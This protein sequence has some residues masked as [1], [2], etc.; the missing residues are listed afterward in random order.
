MHMEREISSQDIV[1]QQAFFLGLCYGVCEP[2]HRERILRTHINITVLCIDCIGGNGHSFDETVGIPF[3]NASIHECAR[4]TLVA[5]T[6]NIVFFY[7]CVG[8]HLFPFFAGGES[9]A[10]SSAQTGFVY[11]VNDVFWRHIKKGL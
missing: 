5:V 7:V 4:I 8:G 3:H 6:D 9:A 11:L 10:A 2:F 1:S